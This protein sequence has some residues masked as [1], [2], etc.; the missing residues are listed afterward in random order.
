MNGDRRL[1]QGL[2][3]LKSCKTH[4]AAPKLHMNFTWLHCLCSGHHLAYIFRTSMERWQAVLYMNRSHK[5]YQTFNFMI[6]MTIQR[7]P[8]GQTSS[9]PIEN[10][11]RWWHQATAAS[12][13]FFRP[14]NMAAATHP[15][16]VG[17]NTGSHGGRWAEKNWEW[18]LD[19]LPQTKMWKNHH[20][21]GHAF[22]GFYLQFSTST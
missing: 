4:I 9:K 3:T 18:K 11:S 5:D 2:P 20:F 8:K 19:T 10:K 21:V 15:I 17:E 6:L 13:F 7:S 1:G 12:L 14:Q 22:H 16:E